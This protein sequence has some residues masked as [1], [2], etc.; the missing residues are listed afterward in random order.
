MI[1]TVEYVLCELDPTKF[2]PEQRACLDFEGLKRHFLKIHVRELSQNYYQAFVHLNALQYHLPCRF[3]RSIPESCSYICQKSLLYDTEKDLKNA[4]LT[5]E[6]L[7]A[8]FFNM[9]I[10]HLPINQ[11]MPLNT[12]ITLHAKIPFLE[13]AKE[14]RKYIWSNNLRAQA[15]IESVIHDVFPESITTAPFLRG[16]HF[17]AIDIGS[18]IH[19]KFVVSPV[20]T[21]LFSSY[22]LFGYRRCDSNKMLIIWIY[23]YYNISVLELLERI[24]Q[25]SSDYNLQ[26]FI[27][28][29]REKMPSKARI[30]N[31]LKY[32]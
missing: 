6:P 26:Q 17:G 15:D 22:S 31:N 14:T 23:N 27:C 25:Q 32:F 3:L 2:T 30:I 21:N 20:D 29:V 11:H 24:L 19:G 1:S 18:E 5:I 13:P 16:A 9:V 10:P 7:H 8:D 28:E 4:A 12:V